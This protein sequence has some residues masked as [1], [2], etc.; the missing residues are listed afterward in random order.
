MPRDHLLTLTTDPPRPSLNATPEEPGAN[1]VGHLEGALARRAQVEVG[2]GML[3]RICGSKGCHGVPSDGPVGDLRG[4]LRATLRPSPYCFRMKVVEARDLVV[5]LIS[6]QLETAI[7][8]GFLDPASPDG[9]IGKFT[10]NGKVAR[11][12]HHY[13]GWH[14]PINL[15]W[16]SG[17]FDPPQI[18]ATQFHWY[19]FALP[20]RSNWT[21]PHYVVIDYLQI[22]EWV[23]DF[24]A[25]RGRDHRDHTDWRADLRPLSDDPDETAGY[26]RWGDEEIGFTLPGRVFQLDNA[27]T[28]LEAAALSTP[29]L[30]VGT[31]GPGGEGAAH[32]L[33]KLYVAA[34]PERI[35]LAPEAH[36]YVEY[37]FATGDRVD[38]MFDN[39][40]PHRTVVE[41]EVAGEMN[42]LV[43]VQQAIKYRSLAEFDGNFGPHS[44]DV[45]STVVAYEVG[46]PDVVEL[47]DRYEVQLIGLDPAEPLATAV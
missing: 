11:A 37:K 16:F 13:D 4:A 47:A 19:V 46:Y 1:R 34:H 6:Q 31:F 41:V 18:N 17:R 29:S 27:A 5:G 25:P 30:R 7:T 24:A 43:G 36:P 10:L 12:I 23:L 28:V 21:R 44:S 39:H 32:R 8:S 14:P 26:F 9:D 33:L 22:R 38:V 35:G 15:D 42:L 2:S 3:K 20:A 45:H 40:R